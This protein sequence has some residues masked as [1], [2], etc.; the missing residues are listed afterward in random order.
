MLKRG[1][2]TLFVVIGIVI[3]VAVAMA[4][5][6]KSEISVRLQNVELS[7]N[8][9]AR[10]LYSEVQA[11]SEDC[12]KKTSLEGLQNVLLN[13]VGEKRLDGVAYY[14]YENEEMFPEKELFAQ[15]LASYIQSNINYCLNINPLNLKLGK[16]KVNVVLSENVE[17]QSEQ[18]ISVTKDDLSVTVNKYNTNVDFNLNIVYNYLKDFYD[19]VKNISEVD[20]IKRGNEAIKNKYTFF[21]DDISETDAVFI[22]Q[23]PNAIEGKDAETKFA[24]KYVV[25]KP[26]PLEVG[27][28]DLIGGLV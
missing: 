12:L 17:I 26:E 9:G 24:M 21:Q 19:D 6:F 3:V 16:S 22:L 18:K 25:A 27:I 7:K 11:Y 8:E 4:L 10:Q 5:I 2:V 20:F 23:I 1:Q 13:G 28:G 15:S 14:L